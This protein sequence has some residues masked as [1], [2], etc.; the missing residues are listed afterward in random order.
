[1]VSES[2]RVGQP[3]GLRPTGAILPLAVFD[4]ADLCGEI[5][6]YVI[7]INKYSVVCG[8]AVSVIS[9]VRYFVPMRSHGLKVRAA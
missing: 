6:Q 3:A 7:S 9:V 8:C 1:L 5:G 4:V 2:P